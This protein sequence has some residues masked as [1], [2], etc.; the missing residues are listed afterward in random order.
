MFSETFEDIRSL[1]DQLNDVIQDEDY[2]T[3]LAYLTEEYVNH[4]GDP[5]FLREA[6]E[7]PLLKNHNLRLSTLKD[8]FIHVVVPSRSRAQLDDLVFIDSEHVS[9]IM[10]VGNQRTIL[11]QLDLR[12]GEWKIGL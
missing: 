9:A 5:A 2:D 7:Q 3:W 4:F 11:Y 12:G 1:I 10:V 6:S 8:Y